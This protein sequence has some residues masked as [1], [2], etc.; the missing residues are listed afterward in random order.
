[1]VTVQLD[2]IWFHGLCQGTE[3]SSQKYD[4]ILLGS[5]ALQPHE[6]WLRNNFRECKFLLIGNTF[7]PYNC[8]VVQPQ[9]QC[10]CFMPRVSDS[11][12]HLQWSCTIYNIYICSQW[13][14]WYKPIHKQVIA[15]P[16]WCHF[17]TTVQNSFQIHWVTFFIEFHPSG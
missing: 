7:C 10:N 14:Q 12:E 5:R 9:W 4:V 8:N 15:V 6:P 1:M 16:V 11:T 3:L 13:I 17:R 2:H